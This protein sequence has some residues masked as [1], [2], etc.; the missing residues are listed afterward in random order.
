MKRSY[1]L[2]IHISTLF[3]L[4][5][6]VVTG[7][8]AGLG[9]KLSRDT[10][11]ATVPDLTRR[12]GRETLG[13]LRRV[14]APAEMAVNL[15]SHDALNS[16]SS[17]N[18][19][20]QS[21]GVLCEALNNSAALSSIYAAYDSGDFFLV[22]RIGDESERQ[23]FKAP[24]GTHYIVQSIE[25]G[26]TPPRGRFIF[27]DAA[28]TTLREDERPD[29]AAGYDPRGR[30][31][32]KEAR[33]ATAQI[34][35]PPYLFFSDRKV[36]MTLATR[37]PQGVVGADIRL[38]TLSTSLAQQKV[39]PGS[40]MVLVNPDGFVIAHEDVGKL[41]TLPNTLDAKPGLTRMED[42]GTPVLTGLTAL[43]EPAGKASGEEPW[44]TR[45]TL[46]DGD[47]RI[48]IN[49][50]LL[51]G[52]QPLYLVIAI[53]DREL[54]AAAMKLRTT[55]L[56]A[57]ALIIALAIP[58]TWATAR[59]ISETLRSL[60]GEAEAIR[61][62]EF[63]KPIQVRSNIQEV[64][65]LAVTMD[66]MKRTIHRFL[67]ITSAVAGEENFARLLPMLLTETLS[68]ADAEAGVLYLVDH[69]Q[70]VPAAAFRNDGT[71]LMQGLLSIPLN[72]TG[73]LMGG[74]IR[75][76]LPHAGRL[77]SQD[78]E[79]MGLDGLTD[80][81]REGVAVPLL[82]R[83]RQ[84]VGAMLLLRPSPIEAA[85]VSFIKALSGSAASSLETRELIQAQKDLFHAFI[86]MIAVA[87]DAKSPYT[88]GHCARVP[89]LTKMLAHAACADGSE[90]FR[91]FKL[92]EAQW[93]ALHV[94]AWLH[95]CGKVTTP[96][97]VVDKAT[98]LE[99]LFD[100]IH[101]IR[102]RFEVLKRDAEIAC[103]KAIAA[104]KEESIAQARLA[105]EIKQLDEDFAFVAACNKGGEAMAPEQIERLKAIATRT[106]T[107]TLDDRLGVSHDERDR[108]AR[109]PAPSL[110]ATESL[111]AD[112]PEHLFE[113]RPQDRMPA[114]NKWNFRMAEPELLYNKGELYNLSVAH[115]T[116]TEEERYKIDGHIV[117]TL[118]MLSQ[119][120]FPKHLRQVPEI[121]GGHHEK[122]DGTGYPKR[123][124][125]EEMSLVARMVAVADIFEALTAEDRPYKEGKK[126]S[127]AI[128]IMAFMKRNQH[129]DP[130][131]FDLFLRSGVYLDYARR[132]MRPEH[133]DAVEIEAYL[134]A[135]PG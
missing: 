6:L 28:L 104:G 18:D 120:P 30:S 109:T 56:L 1:P 125:K 118:I 46:K 63:S 10:L 23:A 35:T 42:L 43:I 44:S 50:L 14:V 92:D 36:G 89:E 38:E 32:Y 115:G 124:K 12:I 127:E 107:R 71:D 59:A 119:L 65:E 129:I 11:E 101:E 69:D 34:K 93:E 114:D 105:A 47:W 73:P 123:L 16:A 4:L 102:M 33:A 130:D 85:Q 110:P 22:R 39:T 86:Q 72:G 21:L 13:E 83:Q 2:H 20:W 88:G 17:F 126:L 75:D 95:D 61:R 31:W 117:Q 108:K 19:R 29:Y 9:Y 24:Q 53:P 70:L 98:K 51:A 48:T 5:I 68:A 128:R 131:L 54:L 76:G 113:R 45:R 103:L 27:L 67:D 87:V 52:A 135:A 94:A 49:P 55:S 66:V 84:L 40:Q 122:M 78:I 77:G 81:I 90:A 3:V 133:I 91:D 100:R 112:K 64:H 116:L 111:L 80:R 62:F 96:E 57:I 8:I 15:A 74:A 79:S 58:V 7:V 82:S 121:A 132:F 106:W 97:Y 60:A 134:G 26:V 37:A 25:R 99:T 41:V